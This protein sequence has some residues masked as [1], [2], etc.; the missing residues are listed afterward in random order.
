MS[1]VTK[2]SILKT[3]GCPFSHAISSCDGFKPSKFEWRHDEKNTESD[4]IVYFDYDLTSGFLNKEDKLKF[5]WLCESRQITGQVFDHVAENAD[6][7]FNCYDAIFVHDREMIE[8]DSRFT[9]LPNAANKHW[10]VDTGIH[11]KSKSISM[12]SSGKKMCVGHLIR[13]EIANKFKD[14]IDLFGRLYNPI[15]KKEEGL[16]DYMFSFAVENASY[17]T[18]YTEKILDCFA[19]GTIPIYLGSP[20][21]GDYFNEDGI[22]ILDEW[23]DIRKLT[24]DYYHSKMDAIKEN[25]QLCMDLVMVDDL[26]YDEILKYE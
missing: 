5:L 17:K 22:V 4:V 15:D 14:R 19:T 2:T 13:N 26:I 12:I 1:T 18:Y 21:I 10:I 23:T 8:K 7:F 9:Y 6:M 25:Y 3:S 24:K 11:K 20:D 16:N